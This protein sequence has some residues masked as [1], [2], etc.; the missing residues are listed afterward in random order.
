MENSVTQPLV[1]RSCGF[2]PFANL[3]SEQLFMDLI[4]EDEQ[5][6][7][8]WQNRNTVVIG[9]NQN[10]W[11]E[12]RIS[13]LEGDG[14]VLARRMSG[15]G[16]VYHDDGNLN[17]TFISPKAHYDVERNLE[18]IVEAVRSFGLDA[19]KSGRNDIEVD[20]AKF[21]GNAFFQT[22]DTCCHHG[23]LMVDVD[24]TKLSRYLQPDPRKLKA[25]S[26]DSVQ[27][28]VVNLHD[29]DARI[30]IESLAEALVAAFSKVYQEEAREFPAQR[31][32]ERSLQEATKAH[33]TAPEW[34]FGE[35]FTPT[36]TIDER[37]TW[38]GIEIKLIVKN[39]IITEAMIYS[40]A[41]D[42]T[43]AES[44]RDHLINTPYNKEAILS[45]LKPNSHAT[46]QNTPRT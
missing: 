33:F 41:L 43:L 5:L 35:T 7:F 40:D 34:R 6:L 15:G 46:P 19:A 45:L 10:P 38:G 13:E 24:I 16:A 21:S 36:H 20:G 17:F 28:R 31:L 32:P 42:T 3:A 22:K 14:G 18:V 25:R 9:R 26:V 11:K 23:T 4:E 1:Y 30:T 12:C 29:L 37:F 2:D 27:S 8:L 44:L 39:K